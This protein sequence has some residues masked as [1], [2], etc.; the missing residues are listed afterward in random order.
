MFESAE[1]ADFGLQ[2]VQ[3][4]NCSIFPDWDGSS[5]SYLVYG[6]TVTN[7]LPVVGDAASIGNQNRCLLPSSRFEKYQS[8][9]DRDWNQVRWGEF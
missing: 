7:P 6:E 2:P 9:Q 4:A 1:L 8:S 5:S 3:R